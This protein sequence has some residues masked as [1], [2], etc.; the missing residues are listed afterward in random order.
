MHQQPL[1]SD[2][3]SAIQAI[4]IHASIQAM[5]SGFDQANLFNVAPLLRL[6]DFANLEPHGFILTIPNL[7]WLHGSRRVMDLR[8]LDIRLQFMQAVGQ[9]AAQGRQVILG[10]KIHLQVPF[11][12]SH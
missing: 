3:C 8:C 1:K 7:A 10:G 5:Q 9:E 11:G 4:A 12:A 6:V 2:L